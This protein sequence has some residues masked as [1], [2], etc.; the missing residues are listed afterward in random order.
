ME[1]RIMKNAWIAAAAL[2]ALTAGGCVTNGHERV[3]VAVAGGGYYDGYYDGGYGAFSDG[4]WGNDGAFWYSDSGHNWH[5]DDANHF[6]A[7]SGGNGWNAVHGSGGH[8]D[9]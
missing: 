9:H 7:D 6:R 4:Y 1:I 2:A 8:R 5:R 3:N